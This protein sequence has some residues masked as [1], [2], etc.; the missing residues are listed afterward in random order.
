MCHVER[1]SKVKDNAGNIRDIKILQL[2]EAEL[3]KCL[4]YKN[5]IT[6]C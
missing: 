3:S 2:N 4:L 6:H 1:K 5:T